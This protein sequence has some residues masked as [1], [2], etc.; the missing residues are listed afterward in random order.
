[1]QSKSLERC[2]YICC[3][4]AFGVF[5]RWLQNQTAF[6]DAGL[7]EKSVFHALVIL[8]LLAAAFLFLRFVDRDKN[9]LFY[10]PDDY[11]QALS[12]EG[13]L[14]TAARIAAGVLMCAGSLALLAGCEA[15]KQAS[16]LRI[17]A[18]LG[19]LSGISF[20]LLLSAANRPV[21]RPRLLCLLSMFPVL[22]FA[23][24]LIVS[25]KMNAINS[26]LWSYA[27]EIVASIIAMLAF[28]H[29]AGFA[30]GAPNGERSIFM[31]MLGG[32]MCLM[33]LADENYLG[34]HMM[35]LA[36]AMMLIVYNWIMV[37]NLRQKTKTP[38]VQPEDGFDRL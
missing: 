38:E 31:S 23:F 22:L 8:F 16:S 12:N 24:W 15:D 17:L 1:M 11:C 27:I 10:L 25:Y 32:V 7:A 29:I 34:M 19:L 26:V 37:K 36:A 13:K 20:P 35:H 2:C 18:A 28:F 14:F 33:S 21:Q 3:A 30:F 5:L 4:G 6:N 9:K